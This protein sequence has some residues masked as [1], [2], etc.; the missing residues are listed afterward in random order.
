M[1]DELKESGTV[2]AIAVVGFVFGL[3]GMLGSFIPC[4]GSLAFY[5]SIPSSIIS[6]IALM[7]ANSQKAKKSFAIV[8]LTIGL[9]GTVVSG[10]QYFSIVAA[11]ESAKKELQQMINANNIRR[12]NSIESKE[13]RSHDALDELK[14][15]E[16]IFEI[17]NIRDGYLNHPYNCLIKPIIETLSYKI[18]IDQNT[19]PPG[20]FF[21]SQTNALEGTPI[22]KG[23]WNLVFEISGGNEIQG[24]LLGVIKIYRILSVGAN[25]DY[26]GKDGVQMA[27]NSAE[28]MDAICIEEGEYKL[29]KIEIVET[30][31]WEHGIK[32]SGGWNSSFTQDGQLRN[33]YTEL[34]EQIS[35]DNTDYF[36]NIKSAKNGIKIEYIIF[37]NIKGG[38]ISV[39]RNK[40][41][42]VVFLNCSFFNNKTGYDGFICGGNKYFI[43]CTFENNLNAVKDGG[44]FIKCTFNSNSDIAVSGGGAFANCSFTNNSGVCVHGSGNFTDCTFSDNNGTAIFEGGYFSNCIFDHNSTKS[45]SRLRGGIIFVGCSSN[46]NDCI[47]RN[48]Y[49]DSGVVMLSYDAT[50]KSCKFENNTS[51]GDGGAVGSEYTGVGYF[52]DCVFDKNSALGSGGAVKGGES[53]NYFSN[54]LFKNNSAAQN[55]GAVS[56]KKE[57]LGEYIIIGC[58]FYENESKE[59]GGAF[60]GSGKI[61]NSI[62]WKNID[63]N[64]ANDITA[65]DKLEIDYSLVNNLSGS[66]NYGSHNIKGDPKFINPQSGNFKLQLDSPCVNAGTIISDQIESINQSYGREFKMKVKI[67]M[68]DLAGKT[69]II[70]GKIDL[71][72]YEYQADN[73]LNETLGS[74]INQSS[75]EKSSS[76]EP[77]R[78]PLSTIYEAEN[79]IITGSAKVNTEHYGFSGRGYVDGYGYMGLGSKTTFSVRIPSDGIYKVTLRY[80][81]ARGSDMTVSIYVNGTKV[82]KTILPS[83]DSWDNWAD[84][85]ELIA[86]KSGQN[87]IAYKYDEGDSGNINIDCIHIS[88]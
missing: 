21:N 16:K 73:N 33:T 2:T 77:A 40:T 57:A 1:A 87:T 80:A 34:N 46:F 24:K 10:F 69:R 50:F 6:G 3:I 31:S 18:S 61:F 66:A 62:F 85:I 82:K 53:A 78:S 38:G 83:M 39:P 37:R 55:G 32:I 23:V 22:Q 19:L 70:S 14:P 49:S 44:N 65:G 12:G 64:D 29:N 63:G 76:P 81:N 75:I 7:I 36:F 71:G 74:E 4:I 51:E 84:K 54:C 59:G 28:D 27:F 42:V 60:Y 9:I 88:R 48:N 86:L 56:L 43:N 72:A 15:T 68:R 58:T 26:T 5:I 11:G 17:N 45:A 47:F 25:G 20:L 79:A 13:N 52:E 8:A 41:D 67:P 30:K 35:A